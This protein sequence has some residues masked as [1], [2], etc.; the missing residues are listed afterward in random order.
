MHLETFIEFFSFLYTLLPTH[1]IW[2]ENK[3]ENLGIDPSTPR[4]QSGR[5]TIW[6]NS[7]ARK[8]SVNN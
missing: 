7:P 5:S 6:T 4:M 8:T 3:M 2:K 1:S